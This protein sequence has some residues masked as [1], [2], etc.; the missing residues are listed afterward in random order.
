[1]AISLASIQKTKHASPPRIVI[2]GVEKT[3]KALCIE[4]PIPT[5]T[6][7]KKMGDLIVG[8]I[9]FDADGKQCSVLAATDV[10]LNRPCYKLTLSNGQSIIADESHL[11]RTRLLNNTNSLPTIRTT[12]EI[13]ESLTIEKNGRDTCN[14]LIPWH[15]GVAMSNKELL[16]DP[17]VLGVWLGDGTSSASSFTIATRDR[18]IIERMREKG[19]FINELAESKNCIRCSASDNFENKGIFREKL[20]SLNL[21]KNKHI[22]SDYLIASHDQRLE[23]LRG[24]MDTDGYVAN[25]IKAMH[26]Y[27]SC[28]EQLIDGVEI[29]LASL[30]IIARKA[31]G[32][33]TLNGKDCG[34]KWRLSFFP[35]EMVVTTKFKKERALAKK[36][37]KKSHSLSIKSIEKI[38]SVPVR[39]IQ[40]SSKDGMFLAGHGYIPT[41][42]S[43]WASQAPNPIF[44]RTEDGLN[45]IETNAFPL[46]TSYQEVREALTVLSNEDHEFKT[47]VIDS[48]DWLE[49]IIHAEVCRRD[50]VSTVA[51]A[52]GGYGAGYLIAMNMW[53]E[54]IAALDYLNRHKAMIVIVICHSAVTTVNDPEHESYDVATLKLHSPKKGTGAADLF[55]EWADV[56]GYAKRP[57][58]VSKSTDEKYKAIDGGQ[59]T[60]ELVIGKNPAC[61]S[62]NRYS[63]PPVIDLTW[64]AFETAIKN[65]VQ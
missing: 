39:C 6:G 61:V 55:T 3:G 44:I 64:Q 63:L 22:P 53:N 10:M 4:T 1:M 7:F 11:W 32:I 47:V 25:D 18:D 57:I 36:S 19:E 16:I 45:G 26:E 58:I 52:G 48:A 38:D 2:H 13:L 46:A 17:Y 50:N 15:K 56:I 12:L 49:R 5:P 14:H 42:N 9:V 30:G 21:L 51:K 33:A 37:R 60:N 59:V 35:I 43:T 62:G 24:L 20:K 34:E 31:K 28:N 27:Y 54:V 40:V 23:L 41:H 29:L 65:S 8:D